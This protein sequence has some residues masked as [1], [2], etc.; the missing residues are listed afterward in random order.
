M[1]FLFDDLSLDTDRREL[2]GAGG[3]ISLEP[4]VFDLL[5]YLICNRDRV[6]SKDDILAAIWHGR[7]VSESALTTRINAARSAIGDSGEAQR[8]IKTLPRKG[9]R[10]VGAVSE[11][12]EPM[13]APLPLSSGQLTP[14][15]LPVQPSIAVLPF[16]N[17]SGD[18]EQEYF[19]DGIVEEIITALSRMRWLFVI[20][21]NSS[22]TYKGRATDIRQIGHELGVRYVLEGSVRK[23]ADQLRITAQLIEAATGA[24]LWAERYDRKLADTFLVQDEIT[25]SVVGAIEPELRKVERQRAIR[26][27]PETMDVWDQC[28]RGMWHFYQ[29]TAEDNAAA[30]AFMRGA[31]DLDP[32]YAQGHVGLSAVF[33]QRILSDWS[34]NIDADRQAGYEAARR[35]VE[36]DDKDP[37]AHFLQASH[38]LLNL[39]HGYS[40]ASAQRAVDLAPNFAMCHF[41]LGWA[42]LFLGKF[43]QAIE[44]FQ[45]AMRLSP[46]DP[47]TYVF[48]IHLALA[49]YH[50]GHYAKA[51]EIARTGIGLR[52]TRMAYRVLAACCGQLGQVSEGQAALAQ[53]RRRMPKDAEKRWDVSYPYADPAHRAAFIDGLRKAG[54]DG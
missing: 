5:T 31:I 29:S 7:I 22:F 13:A 44:S 1:L 30:E 53:M 47:L 36:L 40:L 25:G 32:T 28:A 48:C 17:L 26:K 51:A 2:R 10:F 49:H 9:L 50:Q 23:A 6:V 12:K 16:A 24:H 20:A 33:I 42:R 54:W 11:R 8:L 46:Y 14:P 41:V 45:L 37:T 3:L 4:Q 15:V 34:E 18:P 52:P 19:A 35:A 27:K 39:D 21:R 43:E 38:S